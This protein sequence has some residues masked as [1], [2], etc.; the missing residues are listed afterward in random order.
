MASTRLFSLNDLLNMPPP[1]WLVEGMFEANSLVMV[2]GA[3]GSL[4]S[5]LALDWILSM[6]T[7]RKW[8]GR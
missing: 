6:A 1:K 5:F 7:G 8:H 2:A 3:P 4:K